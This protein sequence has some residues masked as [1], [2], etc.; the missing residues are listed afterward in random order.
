MRDWYVGQKIVCVNAQPIGGLRNRFVD[1]YLKE[2]KVYRIRQILVFGFLSSNKLDQRLAFRLEG[3]VPHLISGVE[4]AFFHGRFRPMES[5]DEDEDGGVRRIEALTSEG[6]R[7]YLEGQAE[8]G[9]AAAAVLKTSLAELPAR[10]TALS[11]ERRR[12]ER[13][14]SEAKKALALAGPVKGGDDDPA[15]AING[16]KAILRIVEGVAAKDL[17]ALADEAK[18]KLGSGVVA[19]ITTADGKASLVVG[20]TPDL[21]TRVSAVDLVR[22]GAEALGGKGGGGRPDMA[23]A[24]GPDNGRAKEALAAIEQRLAAL[25][26][27]P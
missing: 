27:T 7:R 14:L 20:V 26:T 21:T 4:Y 3:V 24:G 1:E 15:R 9:R 17:K 11:E 22:A 12:L 13:E 18:A 5:G 25:E 16:V 2:G 8:A 10:I 6:A 19:F 23:Q